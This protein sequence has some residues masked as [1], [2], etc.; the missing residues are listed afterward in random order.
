MGNCCDPIPNTPALAMV[1]PMNRNSV[2]HSA[3][4]KVEKRFGSGGSVF[5]LLH[6]VEAD[7]RHRHAH[8]WLEPGG[9]AGGVQNNYNF[10]AERSLALYDTPHRAVISYIVDMPFGKGQPLGGSIPALRTS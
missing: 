2:Y 6:V 8:G 5:G 3:Q 4:A 7:Q 1:A 10:A 9:G